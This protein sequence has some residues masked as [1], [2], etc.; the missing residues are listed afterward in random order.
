MFEGGSGY[1]L[2]AMRAQLMLGAL[3]YGVAPA[4]AAFAVCADQIGGYGR[5]AVVFVAICVAIGS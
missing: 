4:A 5:G 3:A 1:R 2:T